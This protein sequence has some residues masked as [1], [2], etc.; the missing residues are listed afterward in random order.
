MRTL[1]ALLLCAAA[2]LVSAGCATTEEAKKPEET[3]AL[4]PPPKEKTPD[5]L[6]QE[7]LADIDANKLDEA[8]AVLQKALEKA[9]QMVN[10]QFDIG[11]VYERR[12]NL[13]KAQDAYEVAHRMDASHEPTLL[14]LGRI[15]RLEGKFEKAVALYEEAVKQPGHEYDVQLLNNLTVAYRL[16]KNYKQA[17]A[18]A[19]KVLSRTKDNA[20]AYKNLTLIYYDQGN[21]K[22][23][24]FI[25]GNARKLDD[26]DPGVY[27]NLGMIYL[28]LDQRPQ[29]LAQ[30]QKAVSLNDKFAPGHV[31]IGAMALTFRDYDTAE[32]EFSKAVSL[33]P[34]SPDAHLYY[35]FAL[36]GQRGKDPKKGPAA[37]AEFERV[38]SLRPDT[39]DA[40]CGAGWAYSS[41][42][43]SWDKAISFLEKCKAQGGTSQQ[44]G[45][46]IDAKLKTIAAMKNSGAASPDQ[47]K[48]EAPKPNPNG[49]NLLEKASEDA[50]KQ[51]GEQPAPPAGEAPKADAKAPAEAPP[52]AK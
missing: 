29:A 18:S 44:D 51:E 24:E 10:A 50:A 47:P 12:G 34:N 1:R 41:D 20:D 13:L 36:D 15:Y 43:G 6:F 11:V 21:Y 33:D 23:A 3:A 25:S 28:K 52:A 46:L 27:N 31:N 2:T 9:P 49:A 37:G 19:R 14:N 38:L 8:L 32:K 26:K 40:V 22:L 30:F 42:R 35:A 45:Q 16:A 39:A 4:P 17:E 5:E 48:K 7:G